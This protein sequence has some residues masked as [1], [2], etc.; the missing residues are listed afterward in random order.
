M[1]EI[2]PTIDNVTPGAV[3]TIERGGPGKPGHTSFTHQIVSS[4]GKE[5]KSHEA[6]VSYVQKITEP[7]M[8]YRITRITRPAPPIPTTPGERFWAVGD[9]SKEPREYL[10]TDERCV[11]D[12]TNGKQWGRQWFEERSTAVPAPEPETAPVP[13]HL[14]RE[15]EVW[16]YGRPTGDGDRLGADILVRIV[17]AVRGWEVRD[18]E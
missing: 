9:I 4:P 14:I 7:G 18:H 11:V 3:V 5:M 10:V 16:G 15:A 17:R 8:G 1:T 2:E 6:T 13:A 12:L